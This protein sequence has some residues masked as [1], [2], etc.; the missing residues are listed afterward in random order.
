MIRLQ[1]A[2]AGDV[3]QVVQSMGLIPDGDAISIDR[4]SNALLVSGSEQMRHRVRVLVDE[5]DQQLLQE[6]IHLGRHLGFISLK[7][8]IECVQTGRMCCKDSRV[9]FVIVFFSLSKMLF[10]LPAFTTSG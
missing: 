4:R 2:N 10:T 6:S 7:D 1:N 3:L 9:S 5:L 8:C